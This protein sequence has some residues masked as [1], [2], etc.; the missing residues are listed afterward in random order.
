MLSHSW[1]CS[2]IEL[3]IWYRSHFILISSILLLTLFSSRIWHEWEDESLHF[4][5]CSPF[6]EQSS[7]QTGGAGAQP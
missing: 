6:S 2:S 7:S 5:P 3:V 1:L 4:L